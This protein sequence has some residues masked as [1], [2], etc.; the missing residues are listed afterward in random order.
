MN[1]T[2]SPS[3]H[4][5]VVATDFSPAADRAIEHAA[6]I[7]RT[8]GSLIRLVHVS[9]FFEGV[10]DGVGRFEEQRAEALESSAKRLESVAARLR[11]DGLKAQA[12]CLDQPGPARTILEDAE[13]FGADLIVLGTRGLTGWRRVLFGS[14]AR[15]V[16]EH[17]SCPVLIVHED[18]APTSR[19]RKVVVATDFSACARQALARGAAMV[20]L[21]A[22]DS[23]VLCHAVDIG[24][25]AA[26][27]QAP[28]NIVEYQEVFCR[29]AE[30][31]LGKEA[32]ALAG[33]AFGCRTE[34]LRGMPAQRLVAFAGEIDADLVIAGGVGSSA[35]AH[36][37]LGSTAERLVS[38][39]PCPVLIVP[40]R[41][42]APTA[43]DDRAGA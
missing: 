30:R 25:F 33:A 15:R 11:A 41:S 26:P 24:T 40:C 9:A 8:H 36:L 7:A 28:F 5:L 3:V 37:L 4:S 34:V 42:A 18:D 2:S 14:T 32:E 23:V 16:V 22:G 27:A 17:A 38:W 43:D 21:G 10:P 13:A 29:E 31:Q 12:V 20:R 6:V 1:D 19:E 39:A 35:V